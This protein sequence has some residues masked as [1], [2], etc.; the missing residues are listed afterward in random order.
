LINLPPLHKAEKVQ[1][2]GTTTLISGKL[3]V[4]KIVFKT[5]IKTN[6]NGK[7]DLQKGKTP[8]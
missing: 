1:M 3:L 2:S 6:K 5:I 8:R 4:I 7:R